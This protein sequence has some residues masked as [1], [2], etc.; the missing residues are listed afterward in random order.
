LKLDVPLRVE[1]ESWA[2][3]QIAPTTT[4]NAA[5]SRRQGILD[6]VDFIPIA[7]IPLTVGSWHWT[8]A[9][10]RSVERLDT[11]HAGIRIGVLRIKN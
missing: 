8:I 9:W 5:S 1:G 11:I 7:D 10:L 2:N 4:T 6:S 3:V